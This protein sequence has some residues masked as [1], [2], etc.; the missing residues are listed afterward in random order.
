[1]TATNKHQEGWIHRYPVQVQFDEVDQYGIVHHPRYFVFM[2]RARVA[3]MGE[4]GMRPG[5]LV[6]GQYGLVVV[7][8]QVKFKAS[9]HFLDELVVE[10]GCG[11]MGAVRVD[12]HYRI[13]R[14]GR[15]LV[16]AVLQLAFVDSTGKPCR[17]PGPIREQLVAMGAPGS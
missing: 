8:A 13:V 17:A 6:E 12:L 11:K 9:A 7:S 4:L 10:Q 2:E 15:P 1:M 5:G 3:L 16:D 14:E